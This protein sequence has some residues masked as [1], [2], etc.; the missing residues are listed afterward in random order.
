[1]RVGL[2]R[3]GH[4]VT[5]RFTST[6]LDADGRPAIDPHHRAA[7]LVNELSASD[8]GASAAIIAASGEISP[9]P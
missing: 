5:A 1:L 4:A 9:V 8:F 3:D 7:D 6:A 2:S